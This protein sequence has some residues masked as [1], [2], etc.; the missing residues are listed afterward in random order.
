MNTE[1][2][3][4]IKKWISFRFYS[5]SQSGKTNIW[6][7]GNLDG[8]F[9]GKIKWNPGWRKYEFLPTIDVQTGYEETC[10]RD[11]ADFIQ[12]KTKEHKGK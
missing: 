3:E 2:I 10:L 7:V 5:K 8:H 6:H 11:I 12:E 4:I 1:K 9:L